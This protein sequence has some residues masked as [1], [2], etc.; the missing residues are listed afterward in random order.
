MLIFLTFMCLIPVFVILKFD[1]RIP[2]GA[3]ILLLV[4]AAGKQNFGDPLALFSYWLLLVGIACLLND[5]L[6]DQ[7]KSEKR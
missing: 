2:I 4:V 1:G 7:I 6:R 5:L 3:A